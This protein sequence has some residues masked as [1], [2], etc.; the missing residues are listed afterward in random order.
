MD[1]L[2]G[3]VGGCLG[4]SVGELIGFP[5]WLGTFVPVGGGCF[6]SFGT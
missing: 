1:G 6:L 3:L 4:G 5:R 2:K